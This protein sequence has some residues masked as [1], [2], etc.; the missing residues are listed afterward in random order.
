MS[1]KKFSNQIKEIMDYL[2]KRAKSEEALIDMLKVLLRLKKKSNLLI[3][4]PI[5]KLL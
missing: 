2:V 5:E 1:L 4:Q 3:Y